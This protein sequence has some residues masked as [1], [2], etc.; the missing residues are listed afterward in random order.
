MK[1]DFQKSGS[2]STLERMIAQLFVN[3]PYSL[4]QLFVSIAISLVSPYNRKLS[5]IPLCICIDATTLYR[6]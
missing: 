4:P 2:S 1:I 3:P 6:K 5:R